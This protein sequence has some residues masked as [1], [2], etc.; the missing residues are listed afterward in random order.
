MTQRCQGIDLLEHRSSKYSHAKKRVEERGEVISMEINN[1]QRMCGWVRGSMN[2]RAA[3]VNSLHSGQRVRGRWR[4]ER[5][6]AACDGNNAARIQ[7]ERRGD[8]FL[9]RGWCHK[10]WGGP[11]SCSRGRGKEKRKAVCEVQPTGEAGFGGSETINQWPRK[12]EYSQSRA[13]FHFYWKC[14]DCTR[15]N[16]PPHTEN[17][18]TP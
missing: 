7:L 6:C 4:D 5:Q 11:V 3:C 16:R 12:L 9:L 18:T 1:Q 14:L 10:G 2:P 8:G 13:V 17:N 15:T